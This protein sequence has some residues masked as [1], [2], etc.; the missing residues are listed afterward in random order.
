MQVND[1]AVIDGTFPKRVADETYET[2]NAL[3]NRDRAL[4]WNSYV[5][6]WSNARLCAYEGLDEAALA[7]KLAKARS[8]YEMLARGCAA[9]SLA[10][11][12]EHAAHLR[13]AARRARI[14]KFGFRL[15]ATTGAVAVSFSAFA[16]AGRIVEGG[17][18]VE[19]DVP[20]VMISPRVS[21]ATPLSHRQSHADGLDVPGQPSHGPRVSG[22]ASTLPV[23][24]GKPLR[25]GRPEAQGS[26]HGAVGTVGGQVPSKPSTPGKA[27]SAAHKGGRSH[28]PAGPPPRKYP[29]GSV[30]DPRPDGSGGPLVDAGMTAVGSLGCSVTAT[31]WSAIVDVATSLAASSSLPFSDLLQQI[32]LQVQAGGDLS[33]IAPAPDGRSLTSDAGDTAGRVGADSPADSPA[34]GRQQ[35]DADNGEAVTSQPEPTADVPVEQPAPATDDTGSSA[36]ASS[37]GHAAPGTLPAPASAPDPAEAHFETAPASDAPQQALAETP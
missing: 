8:A 13:A 22:L 5:L 1:V 27:G 14:K 11:L 21:D 2:L 16:V 23:P 34:A 30:H 36:A 25:P 31:Q 15:A 9:V 35:P 4:V 10:E 32:C 7:V 24:V 29:H 33:V 17:G 37:D 28:K 6:G 18:V 26:A 3:E 12:R 19:A 20:H